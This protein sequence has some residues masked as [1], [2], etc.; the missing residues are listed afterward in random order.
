[1]KK[2]LIALMALAGVAMAGETYWSFEDTTSSAGENVYTGQITGTVTMQNTDVT[3]GDI[4]GNDSDINLGYAMKFENQSYIQYDNASIVSQMAVGTGA[5]DFT[6][7]AYVTFNS[8]PDGSN[9]SNVFFFGTG[10]GHNGIALGVRDNGKIDFLVKGVNHYTWDVTPESGTWYHLAYAYDSSENSVELFINGTSQG[11]VTLGGYNSPAN[12][13]MLG[14]SGTAADAMKKFDGQI[15][16]LQ[17]I[18]GEAL[19]AD[20]VVQYA[21]NIVP[22]PATATLSLL[23]LAGLAARRRRK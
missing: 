2:T 16:H 23:A 13:I 10:T 17:I 1:M 6:V 5:S 15:A 19:G 4:L 14:A 18:T 7:M 12:T 20:A 22:E 11:A 21:S 8:I 3:T 9:D